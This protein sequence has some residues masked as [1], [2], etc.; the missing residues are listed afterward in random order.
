MWHRRVAQLLASAV[1]E[2]RSQRLGPDVYRHDYTL[3]S[4]GAAQRQEAKQQQQR[5]RARAHAGVR[6]V[7][8]EL[9]SRQERARG[10]Y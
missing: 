2:R 3:R 10:Y 1:K 4:A 5:E 8:T 9:E 6:E 7:A